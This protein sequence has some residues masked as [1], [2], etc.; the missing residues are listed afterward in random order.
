MATFPHDQFD[1]IPSDLVRVGAHRAPAK[2]GR[3]WIRFAW[4]ALATG[5]LVVLGLFA[6]SFLNP[7]FKLDLLPGA[8]SAS[9]TPSVSATPTAQAVTDPTKVDPA[10]KLSISVLNGSATDGLQDKAGDAIKAAGWP[11][12]ARAVSTTRSEKTTTI[13]YSSAAY[14]GIAR[15][16]A[17][18]LGAGTVQLSDAFPGAPVTIVVGDDYAAL[19]K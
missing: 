2:R 15:G 18:L 3:G 14:E 5:L 7:A 16:M 1:D 19:A 10:L 12:P 6:L 4:A 9:A 11:D 13:Y 17:V 8:A